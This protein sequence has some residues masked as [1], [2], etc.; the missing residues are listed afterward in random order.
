MTNNWG[1]FSR[2]VPKVSWD[3]SFAFCGTL[4][5]KLITVENCRFDG[6][7]LEPILGHF[8]FSGVLRSVPL[9]FKN[10][11]LKIEIA[12][13][14]TVEK[15]VNKLGRPPRKLGAKIGDPKS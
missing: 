8:G 4:F 10:G 7:F 1:C 12:P 15:G 5:W 9:R 6:S 3:N 2:G 11:P 14:L 13:V